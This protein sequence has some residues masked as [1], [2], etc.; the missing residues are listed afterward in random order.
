MR[1]RNA[2]T[3]PGLE[4]QLA[5][6]AG[7]RTVIFMHVRVRS[8]ESAIVPQPGGR[9]SSTSAAGT[10]SRTSFAA[11]ARLLAYRDNGTVYVANGI[12]G[13]SDSWQYGPR[14]MATMVEVG[15]DSIGTGRWK[16]ALDSSC[17]RDPPP[18]PRHVGEAYDRRPFTCWT[19][20]IL[21]AAAWIARRVPA[22]EAASP[23]RRHVDR[24]SFR[25]ELSRPPT[26][27]RIMDSM[28]ER[29]K[30]DTP[31]WVREMLAAMK[32]HLEEAPKTAGEP[33]PIA[34]KPTRTAGKPT[35]TAEGR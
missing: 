5:S 27:S 32:L 1:W 14:V 19:A 34:E 22:S 12:G 29:P 16:F 31:K 17:F 35:K 4:G 2:G 24:V 10:G 18:G 21:L 7:R 20:T 13:D 28:A 11:R 33:T 15:P 6:A 8:G 26:L 9:D 25:Y 30:D 23:D 3:I